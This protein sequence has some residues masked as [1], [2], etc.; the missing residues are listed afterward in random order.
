MTTQDGNVVI[1]PA[2]VRMAAMNFLS[3]REHSAKE[4]RTKLLKKFSSTRIVDDVIQQLQDH[5]LQSDERFTDA[6]VRMRLRQGK[7]ALVIRMELKEKGVASYLI[8]KYIANDAAGVD[9]NQ[10]ALKVYQKKFGSTPIANLK[11]KAKRVR[12]L[13][14][15]GFSPAN[16]QYVFNRSGSDSN[17]E[18]DYESD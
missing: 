16:I 9:W 10:S 18:Q 12:F 1:S 4:L 8:D 3:M 7:G 2:N 11:D 6:F 15:R 5:K 13:T 17:A 14:T